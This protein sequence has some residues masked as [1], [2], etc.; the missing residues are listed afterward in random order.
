MR[1]FSLVDN[2]GLL[3][4]WANDADYEQVFSA[5]LDALVGAQDL[6]VAVSGSGNSANVLS[7]VRTANAHGAHTFGVTGFAG[8]QLAAL[9]KDCVVVHSDNMQLVEDAHLAIAHAVMCGLRDDG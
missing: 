9:A 6:V 1:V 5:Q 3:T 4:A 2:A 7:A 8:G